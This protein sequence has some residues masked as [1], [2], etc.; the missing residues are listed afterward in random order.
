MQVKDCLCT[1]LSKDTG[2]DV[3]VQAKHAGRAPGLQQSRHPPVLVMQWQLEDS[4]V[5]S[6]PQSPASIISNTYLRAP[7]DLLS[8]VRTRHATSSLAC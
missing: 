6:W 8:V 5:R 7:Y 1:G 3:A 2:C 4:I